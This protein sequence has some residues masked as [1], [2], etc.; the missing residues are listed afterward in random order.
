MT[1]VLVDDTGDA[2]DTEQ[3]EHAR[4]PR[5]VGLL[6]L[7]LHAAIDVDAEGLEDAL[8][9]C[10]DLR[11]RR[12]HRL[13]VLDLQRS[14]CVELPVD[15]RVDVVLAVGLKPEERRLPLEGLG[16]PARADKKVEDATR[17]RLRQGGEPLLRRRSG[18]RLLRRVRL[19]LRARRRR[20]LCGA[21]GIREEVVLLE[22]W[23]AAPLAGREGK[24]NGQQPLAA[25]LRWHLAT[26]GND[27]RAR[28]Q[29]PLRPSHHRRLLS[30]AA[31]MWPALG[32]AAGHARAHV[33]LLGARGR[34]DLQELRD[35]DEVAQ[36][37]ELGAVV[38]RSFP[39]RC[40]A[41]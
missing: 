9:A 19:R 23:R 25:V 35:A 21:G 1:R 40:Y 32:D 2:A 3:F 20:S 10:P 11:G 39:V 37:H 26:Q 14:W 16:V 24:G 8:G 4:R 17:D 27:R 7:H 18:L 15:R 31:G 12:R 34:H 41:P 6:G 22:A 28:Q 36:G 29:L 13:G 38:Q 30:G 33:Q 5:K